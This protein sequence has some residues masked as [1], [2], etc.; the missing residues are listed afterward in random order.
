VQT[1]TLLGL[2]TLTMP[3]VRLV[4]RAAD[5]DHPTPFR[6]PPRW[7]G[8]ES[9]FRPSFPAQH[10]PYPEPSVFVDRPCPRKGRRKHWVRGIICAS[11]LQWFSD[12]PLSPRGCDATCRAP[13][14]KTSAAG[15][16]AIK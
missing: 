16:K 9:G 5:G 6:N 7:I 4:A 3:V 8:L 11:E 1:T 10:R 2:T 12:R 15:R 14:G 13:T